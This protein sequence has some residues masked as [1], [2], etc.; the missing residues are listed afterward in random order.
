MARQNT[1]TVDRVFVLACTAGIVIGLM[2]IAA[3]LLAALAFTTG[4]TIVVPFVATFNGVR[5]TPGSPMVVVTGSWIAASVAAVILVSPL[6]I[7]TLRINSASSARP[8]T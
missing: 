5:D 8:P 6:W 4:T 1:L 2:G 3:M 7:A